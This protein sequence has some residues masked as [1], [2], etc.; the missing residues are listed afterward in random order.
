LDFK[1]ALLVKIIGHWPKKEVLFGEI[2]KF[3]AVIS[4]GLVKQAD[5]PASD[6]RCFRVWSILF[7]WSLLSRI[8]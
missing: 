6:G 8:V 7:A 3:A 4:H 5:F 2:Y 1:H